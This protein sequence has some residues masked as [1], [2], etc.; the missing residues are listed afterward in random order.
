MPTNYMDHPQFQAFLDA[1]YSMVVEEELADTTDI[2]PDIYDMIRTDRLEERASAVG[3]LSQWPEF[4]GEI[5][6]QRMYEQ[7]QTLF[8]PREYASAVAV[9]RRMVKDDLTN[10]LSGMRFRPM[11][12]AAILTE[13]THATR[14]FEM[15]NVVD[16]HWSMH[17]ENVP[18]VSLNH[19]TRTPNVDTSTGFGNIIFEP[20][21]PVAIRAAQI[22][23]RKIKSSEGDRTNMH[24]DVLFV[25]VDQVPLANT[26]LRTEQGL[27]TPAMNENQE[28]H[29][30]SGIR[31]VIGLPHWT[32]S[33]NWVLANSRM[34]KDH[35]KWV[36]SETPTYGRM[37]EFH[38]MQI[39][40]RGYM[41][42]GVMNTGW[43]WA[44]GGI[45]LVA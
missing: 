9:T 3:G 16:T 37:T 22:L 29:S 7:Y 40:S 31:R 26:I 12:R 1:R 36:T 20:L 35:L 38:T 10:V 18:I 28:S 25:P 43:R 4:M 24:Y 8:R 44:F 17:T 13:Q 14:L 42:H 5:S 39:K 11:V 6:F 30:R 21:S 19:T 32:S 41:R 33:S 15:I 27:D 34:M 45:P 2:R 23:G